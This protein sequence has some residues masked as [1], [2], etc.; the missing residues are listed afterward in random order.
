MDILNLIK[1]NILDIKKKYNKDIKLLVICNKCDNME[2]NKNGI[3]EMDEPELEEMYEQIIKTLKNELSII[4]YDFEK[5][6][7]DILNYNFW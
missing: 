1:N 3:L 7:M 6:I 5:R 4:N 2:L